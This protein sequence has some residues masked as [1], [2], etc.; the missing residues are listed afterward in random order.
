MLMVFALGACKANKPAK[1][2]S[3]APIE[4][5]QLDGEIMRLDSEGHIAKIR[6]QK[7]EGW[8]GAMTMEFPV[9]DQNE[10]A[11][12]QV[13]DHITA[14]VYVQDLNFWIGEIRQIR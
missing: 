7:I 3:N 10:F 12:L 4:R 9:K 11:K 13:G 5:Y 6:H 8:M 2:I 1:P 14:T